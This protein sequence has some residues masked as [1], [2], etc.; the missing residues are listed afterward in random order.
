M[1]FT[2][3][4]RYRLQIK[5]DSVYINVH[6]NLNLL[7]HTKLYIMTHKYGYNSLYILYIYNSLDQLSKTCTS[8][9]LY[10]S[11]ILYITHVCIICR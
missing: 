9:I 7:H 8:Q 3:V 1:L 11:I 5:F 4:Y 10:C 6:V 2:Y